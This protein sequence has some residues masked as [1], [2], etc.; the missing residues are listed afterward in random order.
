MPFIRRRCAMDNAWANH[1]RLPSACAALTQEEI[2]APR[3]RILLIQVM[4]NHIDPSIW[5]MW[6]RC[7]W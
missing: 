2:E 7:R 6:M 3:T 1:I 5:S 4:R